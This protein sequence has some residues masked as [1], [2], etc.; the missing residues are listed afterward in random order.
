MAER[1]TSSSATRYLILNGYFCR[2]IEIP[3]HVPTENEAEPGHLPKLIPPCRRAHF[4]HSGG[5]LQACAVRLP[6]AEMSAAMASFFV[7]RQTAHCASLPTNA[8]GARAATLLS[9]TA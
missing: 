6:A 5:P 2:R 8:H 1:E 3:S 7:I 9:C 4:S